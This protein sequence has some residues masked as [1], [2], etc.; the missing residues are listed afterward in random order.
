MTSGLAAWSAR[1][2]WV[3]VGAALLLAAAGGFGW[4]SL[5]RDAVPDLSDPQVAVVAVWMGHPAVAVET[6]VTQVLTRALAG[7][8][9]STAVRAV[10]MS[11]MAYVEVVLESSAA[12]DQARHAIVERVERVRDALPPGLRLEVGPAASSTSWVLQYAL[13]DRSR[14]AS[15]LALRRLQ[16]EVLRPALSAIPGVAEVAPLGGG[17]EQVLVEVKAE[18]LEASALAF[19]DVVSR[20]SAALRS[21]APL[22]L[23]AL[24]GLGIGVGDGLRVRLDNVANVRIDDEMPSGVADFGGGWEAVGGIVL[25]RPDARLFSLVETVKQTLDRARASFPPDV[26]LVTVY[27]RTELASRAHRTL[28]RALGEEVAAAVVVILIFLLHGR[29]ALVP[30]AT[31]P[32][33]VLLTFAGMAVL[34][35]PATIMSLGGIGIALGMAVDADV[36]AL[37][38]C[39]RRMEGLGAGA[40]GER[41]RT[42]L[43]VATRALGPAIVTS[44]IIT[45]LAF[46]PVFAFTGETGRL[47][48]PLALTKTLVVGSAAIVSLTLSPALRD[49]LVRGRVTPE[50]DHPLTRALVRSYRPF[51]HF[52][53]TRPA[54][55]IATAILAIASCLPIVGRLGGEFLPRVDE[56][57]LLFMP[58]T[59]PG[60]RADRAAAQLRR[61][62]RAIAAFPEIETVFGKVG[63]AETATDPAPF[64]MAETTIRLRPTSAWPAVARRRWFSGWAPAPLRR[65]LAQVWPEETTET[66]AELTASLDR[67]TRRTGWSSAWTAPARARIDMMSTGIRTPVGIRVVASDRAGI[68]T[69]CAALQALA[70]R[71]SG[72]RSAVVESLGGEARLA[73]APD[74]DALTL[75]RVDADAVQAITDLVLSGGQVGEIERGGRRL[76]VRITPGTADLR[77][78]ADQLREVTVRSDRGGGQPV[79]LALVGRPYFEAT[80]AAVRTENGERVA[81]VHIDLHEGIDPAGYVERAQ[82][83]VN[84]ALS[85]GQ[86]VLRP[87]ERIEWA[88]QYRLFSAGARRLRWIVAMAGVSMLGLLSFQLRSLVEA[89]IVAISV[90]FALVGS[91]WTL[92]LLGYPFSAPVWVG[93]LSVA[94]LAMQ[95]GVVMVVYIDESFYAHVRKGSIQRRE[96][97]VRAHEEGTVR[98]LRPKLMTV[99]TMAAALLPLLWAGG[100][101]AEIMKRVAAPMVGGLLTSAFLT[102][103]VL[104]VLYTLWRSYQLRQA[105]RTGRSIEQVVG[106]IPPWARPFG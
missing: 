94:G 14:R 74:Q 50:F 62:D 12:L 60:V 3:V 83:E 10:S 93:L 37:E 27:D 44:L 9:G 13:F 22:S 17:A 100:A 75:H 103:E 8:A 72:A 96:D 38:A 70:L 34:G 88:G 52:A 63:R 48:R 80:P 36:V 99:S 24:Q 5:S 66:V 102:L 46:L 26:E 106:I 97:V 104:P 57:D 28:I 18:P 1:H 78:P 90:P 101:G 51:V 58:T 86:L 61:Q 30:L 71:V 7:A 92:F 87:G 35:V 56:G 40:S 47:L 98:R 21:G 49:R 82:G 76:R 65:A 89:L 39:H 81:Y 15:P 77:G 68:D 4:R 64:S 20:V 11:G 32:V 91:L 73:F 43:I 69:L 2:P 33:I 29:S 25:A 42:E 6:A 79:A 45:A 41:R 84:R 53:L 19:S 67:A 55:T 54:L 59:V 95:T 23:E 31:L 16:D 85:T 105:Q